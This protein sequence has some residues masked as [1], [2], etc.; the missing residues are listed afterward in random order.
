MYGL[1]QSGMLANRE[2]K[3]LL[4]KAVY[5]PSKHIAGIFVHKTRPISFTLVVDNFG[6]KYINKAVTL[7][8]DKNICDHYPMKSDWIGDCYIGIDLNWDYTKRLESS[9]P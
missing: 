8:L 1:K 5:F 7:H 3:K 2:L 9:S 6:V 4:A